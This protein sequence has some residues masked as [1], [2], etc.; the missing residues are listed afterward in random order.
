[1]AWWIGLLIGLALN[2]VAYLIMPKPKT[3]KAEAAKDM[4]APTAEA[5]RPVPVVFGTMTVKGLNVLWYG[6]KS[7]KTYE[8]KA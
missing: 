1:M 8:V 2:I 6:D 4:D 5:G 7:T 3:E